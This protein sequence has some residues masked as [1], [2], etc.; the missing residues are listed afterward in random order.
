MA[1][2]MGRRPGQQGTRQQ[3]IDAARPLFA[4]RGFAETSV[5]AI[6]REA[7]VDPAMINHWFGSKEGLFQAILDLPIDPITAI[8]GVAD[9]PVEQIPQQLLDRF[10]AVWEDPELSDAMAIVLRRALDDPDQRLL[11]RGN[12]VHQFIAEPLRAALARRDPATADRRVALI[13]TQMLGVIVAR[14]VVGVEPLASLTPDQLHALLLP[15][16]TH[17]MLG[18]L[19]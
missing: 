15:A 18:D 5:R 1:P 16:L 10:L 6:A 13:L 8:A 4:A 14:K 19:S 3:I 2:P 17:H 12:V 7:G 11:L 9:G